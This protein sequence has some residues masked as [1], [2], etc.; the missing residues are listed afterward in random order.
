[1]FDKFWEF[2]FII[3]FNYYRAKVK[4][5][6]TRNFTLFVSFSIHST[7]QFCANICCREILATSHAGG[8]VRNSPFYL[9]T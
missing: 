9:E 5:V 2:F 4:I 8:I 1:M 7:F 6:K 3:F